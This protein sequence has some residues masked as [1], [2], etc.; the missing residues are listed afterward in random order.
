[1]NRC[2]TCLH[3]QQKPGEVIGTC[4]G[5]FVTTPEDTPCLT[6]MVLV[7]DKGIRPGEGEYWLRTGPDF[8][9]VHHQPATVECQGEGQ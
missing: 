2:K 9:C 6:D 7:A 4:Q 8:G 5:D 1:M 3:W